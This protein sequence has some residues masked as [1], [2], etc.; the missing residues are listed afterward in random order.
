M[1]MENTTF[2][3]KKLP[4]PSVLES[5]SSRFE[6]SKVEK[7]QWVLNQRDWKSKAMYKFE[8]W[9]LSLYFYSLLTYK[10]NTTRLEE[11]KN[12]KPSKIR[13]QAGLFALQVT[14]QK[15]YMISINVNTWKTI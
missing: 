6:P 10:I 1:E 3:Y 12:A 8:Q 15:E 7:S 14:F 13:P 2:K 4:F 5:W 9:K 11:K